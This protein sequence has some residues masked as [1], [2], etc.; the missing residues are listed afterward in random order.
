MNDHQSLE[1]TCKTC[2]GHE[3]TVTRVWLVTTQPWGWNFPRG[4]F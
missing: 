2:G 1:F 4:V 3:L